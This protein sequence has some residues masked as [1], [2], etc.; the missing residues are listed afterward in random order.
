MH[1]GAPGGGAEGKHREQRKNTRNHKG[2]GSED[3]EAESEWTTE[4]IVSAGAKP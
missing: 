2:A 1:A 4:L 3:K